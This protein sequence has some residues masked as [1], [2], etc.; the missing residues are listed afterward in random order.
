MPD[1]CVP[2]KSTCAWF[3]G[4]S[5]CQAPVRTRPIRALT[6]PLA[7]SPA[8]ETRLLQATAIPAP[9]RAEAAP[10]RAVDPEPAGAAAR[11]RQA[12]VK[13]AL[14]EVVSPSPG[15]MISARSMPPPG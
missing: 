6:L 4:Y 1:S 8:A 7:E 12:Q 5:R 3:V 9:E 14:A 13:R 2:K 15:K 10:E 11:L